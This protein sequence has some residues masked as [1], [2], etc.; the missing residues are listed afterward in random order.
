MIGKRAIT[1]LAVAIFGAGLMV[2]PA[3]AKCGRDCR[4]ALK[5][6]FKACKATCTKGR[7]GRVCKATCISEF[8]GAKTKCRTAAH[9]VPPACSPSGAF[10]DPSLD[11]SVARKAGAAAWHHR[12]GATVAWMP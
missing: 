9:P 4:K 8:K 10:I 2:S 12:D 11:W 6:D 1:A 5:A 7:S 3:L